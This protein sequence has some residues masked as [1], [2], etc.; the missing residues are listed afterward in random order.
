MN[1]IPMIQNHKLCK[2]CKH[3]KISES[4]RACCLKFPD[5]PIKSLVTGE[6]VGEMKFFG[7]EVVRHIEHL[8]D[9]TGK[10]FEPK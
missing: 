5:P 8:C 4:N 2:D 3:M 1:I 9:I 6:F 7:C 10:L